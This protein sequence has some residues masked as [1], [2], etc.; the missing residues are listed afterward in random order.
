MIEDKLGLFTAIIP[1]THTTV[2]RGLFQWFAAATFVLVFS[3]GS[4]GK[5]SAPSQT[6]CLCQF[7]SILKNDGFDVPGVDG[8]VPKSPRARYKS[9]NLQEIVYATMMKPG[10]EPSN[11]IWLHCARD[12]PG[13]TQIQTIDV[14]VLQLWKFDVDGKV[15]AYGLTAGWVGR[16]DKTGKLVRLGTA[17]DKLFYDTDGSGKFK[18]MK[19]A[20]FPFFIEVPRWVLK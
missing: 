5:S 6:P 17:E 13:V 19:N 8:A 7:S 18:L 12:L 1:T 2:L 15:F 14:E 16:E 20:D 4:I 11:I 9:D 3:S 10:G